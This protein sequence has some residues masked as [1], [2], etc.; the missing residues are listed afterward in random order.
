MKPH[1]FSRALVLGAPALVPRR[2]RMRAARGRRRSCRPHCARARA[3]VPG[4]DVERASR[5]GLQLQPKE[6]R[7]R[8]RRRRHGVGIQLCGEPE[9][10]VQHRIYS[11]RGR[12][13]RASGKL[14]SRESSG[15]AGIPLRSRKRSRS[16]SALHTS[17]RSTS[18]IPPSRRTM[19]QLGRSQ[20]AA[21]Y[22]GIAVDTMSLT[23]DWKQCG[24]FTRRRVGAAVQRHKRTMPR[25]A[26]RCSRGTQPYAHV[27]AQVAD[28]DH[29]G[30]L[31]VRV[32]RFAFG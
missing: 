20:L 22:A 19:G 32:R 10:H 2:A 28:G 5:D 12:Q 29:P 9:R 11:V 8:D 16:S 24:H 4:H 23:N 15:L 6:Y 21:G 31:L 1:N 13:L 27:H 25:S 7:R 17:R 18:P 26:A 14:V 3:P 30:E